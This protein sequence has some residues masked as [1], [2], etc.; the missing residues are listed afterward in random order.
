MAGVT[1]DSVTRLLPGS[2]PGGRGRPRPRDLRR[3]VPRPGRARPGAAR[4]P[5]CGC[6]PGWRTSTAAGS[7]SASGTSRTSPP[8]DRDIAMVFQNYALYPHM[9]VAD[10][11]GFALKIAGTPKAEIVRRVAEAAADPRPG[12][13]PRAQAQGAVRRP[14]PAGR[15]GPG[16]RP[17]AAGLPDGRAA[18]EPRRQA[19]GADPDRD[20]VAAAPARVDHRL[21]HPRPGGGDDDGRPGRG[22][23]GRRAA[24]VRHPAELYDRPANPFVAGF[25][26]SPAMNLMSVPIADGGVELGGVPR[27]GRAG[28]ARR[29]PGTTR[30]SPSASGRRTW[31]VSPTRRMARSRS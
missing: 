8:K 16:D 20:R 12:A 14:A 23:Q 24:A 31:R 17:S 5:R 13:L 27:A 21:R 25:I 4:P 10:N 28:G 29:P 3:G 7:G 22:A 1:Y 2:P 9:S 19:A 26:G 11:M 15:D 18:V 30:P 6:S